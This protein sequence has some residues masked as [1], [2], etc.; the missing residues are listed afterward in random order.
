MECPRPP[1]L[2]PVCHQGMASVLP[3]PG[4]GEAQSV[5]LRL[6]NLATVVVGR[7][8]DLGP[9]IH[10]LRR[11]GVGEE[12]ARRRLTQEVQE[13]LARLGQEARLRYRQD[14]ED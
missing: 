7:P 11:E 13:V 8:L 3:N 10:R 12:E 9:L 4:E 1:L 5:R 2:L 6:G 14:L